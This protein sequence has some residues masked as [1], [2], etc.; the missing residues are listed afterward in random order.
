[1]QWD[2]AKRRQNLDKHGLD[3][4]DFEGFDDPPLEASDDRFDYGEKRTIAAGRINGQPRVIIYTIRDG[5]VRLISF[6]PAH[7][8]ELRQWKR[9]QT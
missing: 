3:F 8:K 1:M 7:E 5:Q 2:E 9:K 6:R 4:A